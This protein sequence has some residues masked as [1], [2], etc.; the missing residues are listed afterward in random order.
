MP[1]I[2]AEQT[3]HAPPEQ[4]ERDIADCLT[5]WRGLGWLCELRLVVCGFTPGVRLEPARLD[6]LFD[7]LQQRRTFH[8]ASGAEWPCAGPRELLRRLSR[9]TDLS[10]TIRHSIHALRIGR[11]IFWR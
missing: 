5:Q 8:R 10:R 7:L 11:S 4:M 3:G 9:P 6:T 2:P 1:S